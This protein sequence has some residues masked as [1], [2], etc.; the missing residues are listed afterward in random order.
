MNVW[1]NLNPDG[2]LGSGITHLAPPAPSTDSIIHIQTKP[3]F[4]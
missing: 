2:F 4:F 3:I 1:K